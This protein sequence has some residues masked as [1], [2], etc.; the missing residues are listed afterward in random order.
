MSKSVMKSAPAFALVLLASLHATPALALNSVSYVSNAGDDGNNCR[1]IISVCF[2]LQ[3]A[4]DVTASGGEIIVLASGEYHRVAIDRSIHI[5]NDGVGTANISFFSSGENGIDINAGAGDV[6]G[7]RGLV[8]DGA[9]GMGR[10]G[11]NIATVS[12]VHI[13]NCV[14]RNFQGS[15]PSAGYGIALEP[16]GSTQLFVSDTIIYNNG[17]TADSGGILIDAGGQFAGVKAM[18]DRVHVENNVIGIKVDGTGSFG[19]GFHVT[20]RNSVVSGNV[21]TG[22]WSARFA[23]HNGL[24]SSPT[25]VVVD[26]T[27]VANNGGAGVLADGGAVVL[28]RNSTVEYNGTGASVANGGRLFTYGNNLVDNNVGEDLSPAAIARTTR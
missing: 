26:G 13:Q 15:G 21:A 19:S 6:V 5:T 4:H 16:T 22:I 3:R 2:S 9:P 23:G 10:A 14:I 20:V 17:S 12:A 27:A 11:I 25:V 8:I 24:G 1:S 7:L 28:L 18:L